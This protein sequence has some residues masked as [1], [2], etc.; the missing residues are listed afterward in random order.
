[1]TTL[2]IKVNQLLGKVPKIGDPVWWAARGISGV[3]TE[4]SPSGGFIFQGGNIVKNR[5]GREVP[6]WTVA[7]SVKSYVWNDGGFWVVGKGPI[8]KEVRG[9]VVYPKPVLASGKAVGSF[10]RGK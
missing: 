1:M 2:W 3:I 7:A 5:K 8:P 10:G 9:L 6:R 4:Q